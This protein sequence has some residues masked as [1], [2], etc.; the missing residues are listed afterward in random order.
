[1][2]RE[3]IVKYINNLEDCQ[4]YIQY[5]NRPIDI[6][7]DVFTDKNPK[8]DEQDGFIYEAHFANE[9]ESIGIRQVNDAWLVSVTNIANVETVT[10]SAI[11]DLKVKMA[12]VWATESDV[13]CEG[14]D[15]IKLQKVVF[16]GFAEGALK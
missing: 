15:V 2:T 7:K 1:M 6:D 5:S 13:L 14:M 11:A 9:K 16:A 10:F 8:V 3:E 4:G 12:Q